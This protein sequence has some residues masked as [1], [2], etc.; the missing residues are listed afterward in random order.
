MKKISEFFFLTENFQFFFF[1]FFFF[2]LFCFVKFSMYLNK[3][4]FMME[5]CMFNH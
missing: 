1:F 2:F 4:V 5:N 3:R